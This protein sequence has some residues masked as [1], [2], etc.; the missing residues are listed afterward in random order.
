[1]VLSAKE[2]RFFRF[3]VSFGA[4]SLQNE[5]CDPHFFFAFLAISL[6]FCVAILKEKSVRGNFWAQTPL[7]MLILRE[8]L[9]SLRPRSLHKIQGMRLI[10]ISVSYDRQIIL[11]RSFFL[12]C[13]AAACRK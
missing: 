10:A 3:R 11:T 7:K 1:M 8:R 12:F 6:H 13:I 4:C 5:V 9:R 2:A